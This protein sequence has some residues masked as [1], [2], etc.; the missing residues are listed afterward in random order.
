M[1]NHPIAIKLIEKLEAP[2]AAPSA[3]ISGKLS[4]T[5]VEHVIEDLTGK[6]D[7]IIAGGDCNIGIESTVVD[8]TGKMPIILR[9]GGITQEMLEEVLGKV[10]VNFPIKNFGGAK[11]KSESTGI[12]YI[13]YLPNAEMVIIQEI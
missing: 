2:I 8:M 10:L 5:K 7:A 11:T 4:P 13:D 6:V 1:P 12:R 3:N 9:S